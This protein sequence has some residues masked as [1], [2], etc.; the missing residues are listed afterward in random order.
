MQYFIS[1]YIWLVE[2]SLSYKLHLR[3]R[4]QGLYKGHFPVD[5]LG[6]MQI[7]LVTSRAEPSFEHFELGLLIYE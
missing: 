2:A 5:L 4:D 3:V 1:M 7:G 6:I